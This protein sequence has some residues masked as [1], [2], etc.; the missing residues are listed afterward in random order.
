MKI[1]EKINNVSD[2]KVCLSYEE[3][4]NSMPKNTLDVQ[5]IELSKKYT[6]WRWRFFDYNGRKLIEISK[7]CPN[8]AKIRYINNN[9]E[10]ITDE[11]T[12][13]IDDNIWG[14]YVKTTKYYYAINE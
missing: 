13:T 14:K 10:W 4:I 8:S 3:I 2:N 11:N 6:E 12:D 9:G 5:N 7:K 1:F